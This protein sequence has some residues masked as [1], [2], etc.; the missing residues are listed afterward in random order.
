MWGM[1]GA[2]KGGTMLEA[3]Q[4]IERVTVCMSFSQMMVNP[5]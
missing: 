1:L 3:L 4:G 2:K 5:E